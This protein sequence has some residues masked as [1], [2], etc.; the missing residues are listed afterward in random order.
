MKK[1]TL[2]LV[3]AALLVAP[4]AVRA[5]PSATKGAIVGGVAGHMA[6]GHTK[7][8]AVAGA[9]IGHHEKVKAQESGT[10]GK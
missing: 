3:A 8:G 10:A 1:I 7:T 2:M 6:G 5:E 4:L 9:V